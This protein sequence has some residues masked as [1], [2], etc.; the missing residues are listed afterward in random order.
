MQIILMGDEVKQAITEY[1]KKRF[2]EEQTHIK[3]I[4]LRRRVNAS[5]EVG[6]VTVD[7][8]TQ[9]VSG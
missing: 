6:S 9:R 8:H 2:N 3:S 4:K 5:E 7:L 1:L